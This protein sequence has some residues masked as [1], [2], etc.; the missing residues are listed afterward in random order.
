MSQQ[1]K[2]FLW[3][4]HLDKTTLTR[5]NWENRVLKVSRTEYCYIYYTSSFA[6]IRVLGQWYYLWLACFFQPNWSN[7]PK[8]RVFVQS[9]NSH[10]K[11]HF[12]NL[13]YPREILHGGDPPLFLISYKSWFMHRSSISTPSWWSGSIRKK[14]MICSI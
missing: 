5:N 12:I 13:S 2:H 8:I 4:V 11:T 1:E 14:R 6:A 3:R 9:K 7:N 10:F